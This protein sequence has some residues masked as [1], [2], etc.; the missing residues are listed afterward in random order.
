MGY[1]SCQEVAR[2]LL[3]FPDE[4]KDYGLRNADLFQTLDA[5][6]S[7]KDLNERQMGGWRVYSVYFVS[8]L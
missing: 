4:E 2:C 5:A 8:N 6:G 3:S 7:P 1:H